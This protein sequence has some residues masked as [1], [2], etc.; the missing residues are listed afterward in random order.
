MMY[1]AEQA[2]LFPELPAA[3]PAETL[4]LQHLP[5]LLM[6]TNPHQLDQCH[7]QTP[8]PEHQRGRQY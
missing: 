7:H 8:L 1:G 3:A 6:R 4:H 5:S 2:G